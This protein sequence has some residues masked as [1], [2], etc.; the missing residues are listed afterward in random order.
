M[1]AK[2]GVYKYEKIKGEWQLLGKTNGS[3]RYI[4]MKY[5]RSSDVYLYESAFCSK[6]QLYLTMGHEYI[7]CGFNIDRS[8]G[9]P[10]L[11]TT[12]R[13]QEASCYQWEIQQARAWGLENYAAHMERIYNEIYQGC[14]NPRYQPSIPILPIRP[15]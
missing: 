11:P 1:K 4:S 6:E 9:N 7:H 5:I 13:V 2:D 10:T 12:K 14:F 8:L 15:W 3:T